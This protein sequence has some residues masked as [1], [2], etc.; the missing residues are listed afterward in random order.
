MAAEERQHGVES[1][2]SL[3][4]GALAFLLGLQLLRSFFS[5]AN[6]VLYASRGLDPLVALGLALACFAGGFLARPL[7]RW[8]GGTRAVALAAAALGVARLGLQIS[9]SPVVDLVLA[10]LGVA[11][12]FLYWPLHLGAAAS[13]GVGAA[14]TLAAAHLLAL[15]ADAALAT[16]LGTLDLAWQP[17]AWPLALL[18]PVVLLLLAACRRRWADAAAELRSSQQ[19]AAGEAGDGAAAAAWGPLPAGAFALGPW[20]FLQILAYH[21]AGALAARSGWGL[22]AS[23]LMVAVGGGLGLAVAAV[24]VRRDAEPPVSPV[25]AVGLLLASLVAWQVAGGWAVAG[26]VVGQPA[27]AMLAVVAYSRPVASPR[28]AVRAA[29]AS[30]SGPLLLLLLLFLYYGAHEYAL[31]VPASAVV[32]LAAGLVVVGLGS[33]VRRQPSGAEEA[34]PEL[35][36]VDEPVPEMSATEGGLHPVEA[37]GGRPPGT[38]DRPLPA[39]PWVARALLIAAALAF[40]APLGLWW[41]WGSAAQ[42]AAEQAAATAPDGAPV[43]AG[44]LAEDREVRVMTYNV[45]QGFGT[46]GRLDPEALAGVIE[47]SG[48]EIVAMQEVSRGWLPAGSLDLLAWLG[49]RLGMHASW[50]PTA[51]GQWGNALLSRYPVR[52][53]EAKGLPPAD[54]PLPRGY[55]DT[56]IAVGEGTGLRLLATHLHHR[57]RAH[58]VREEQVRELLAAWGETPGTVILGDLNATPETLAIGLFTA[59]GLRNATALVPP[60]DRATF[61]AGGEARQIDYIWGSPDLRF[62]DPEI[63]RSSASDHLPV[64]VTVHLPS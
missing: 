53:A 47:A 61:V 46:D 41:A 60:E 30:G 39:D 19:A 56:E 10:A 58:F 18:A 5:L 51:G 52:R 6:F 35:S 15:A 3:L 50:G 14:R 59:S 48:A 22:P 13:R 38:P 49:Q 9:A 8:L 40:V 4:V 34:L 24:L 55:L 33:L 23:C 37:T 63:P 28:S 42:P 17:G 11:F 44:P 7:G 2:L 43:P 45:H 64:V 57:R 26:V 54:L 21:N 1:P 32:G 25:P 12:F 31:G 62:T 20:L 16:S 27:A 29:V 36:A